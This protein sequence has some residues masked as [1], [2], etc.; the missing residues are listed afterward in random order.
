[1]AVADEQ[2]TPPL[3]CLR[4]AISPGRVRRRGATNRA[5]RRSNAGTR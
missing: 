1:M 4:S 2:A 5:R 3:R